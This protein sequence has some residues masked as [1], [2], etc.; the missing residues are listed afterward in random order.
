MAYELFII[1]ESSILENI[2]TNKTKKSFH[3]S[4]KIA[5]WTANTTMGYLKSSN[6]GSPKYVFCHDFSEKI[7]HTLNNLKSQTFLTEEF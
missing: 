2:V 1:V 5:F 6:T 3:N 4:V 7:F